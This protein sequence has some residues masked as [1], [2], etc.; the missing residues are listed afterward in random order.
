MEKRSRIRQFEYVGDRPGHL[1]ANRLDEIFWS[2]DGPRVHK[3]HHYLEI[4][5]K[6]FSRF[7]GRGDVRILEIGVAYGGSLS[8]WR[9]YFGASATIFGIDIAPGCARMSG[10]DGQVRIGSQ[11]DPDFLASVVEEM[12][13]VDIVIDDGSHQCAHIVRSFE[14]LFPMLS[15]GGIYLAEDLHT[16]YWREFGGGYRRSGS[17]IELAKRMVDDINHN[18]HGRGQEFA[19][20]RDLVSSVHFYDS[21]V[22]LDRRRALT[23]RHSVIGYAWQESDPHPSLGTPASG[24]ETASGR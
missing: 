1:P 22:V 11:T 12:G 5:D 17:F 9:K 6:H 20:A 24:A 2:H 14:I 7:V 16:N 10:L 4:Y 3:W 18:Y 19:F 23:P 21:I 8:V 13:G 15:D